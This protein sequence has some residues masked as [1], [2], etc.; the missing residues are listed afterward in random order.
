[1]KTSSSAESSEIVFFDGVCNLCNAFVDFLMRK[2]TSLKFA[3]LQG[4]TAKELLPPD[5]TTAFPSVVY[6]SWGKL[7]TESTAAI[8]I[9]SKLGGPYKLLKVFLIVPPFIRDS[10]YR[11][12]A[13]HRYAWFGKR[14]TCRLPTPEE[15]AQFL[16]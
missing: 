1:V 15:R 11:F 8:R 9:L 2:K 16:D 14:E 4:K 6:Y 7:E 13:N 3:S 10:V 12:I 5:F